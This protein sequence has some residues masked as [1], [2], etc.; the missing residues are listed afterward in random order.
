MD[1]RKDASLVRC[2]SHRHSGYSGACVEQIRHLLKPLAI[3]YVDPTN[4][5]PEPRNARRHSRRQISQICA[6]M[7][8]FG[9]IVPV[10]VDEKN[11]VLAGHGRLQAALRLGLPEVP[12]V[13][14]EHLTPE[15]KRAFRLA[16]NRLA[17]L[18]TWDEELLK[19]ELEELSVLDLHFE[20]EVTGFDSADLDRLVEPP[21]KGIHDPD[22][23]LPDISECAV[24]KR[25]DVWKAGNHLIICGD[26]RERST[27]AA[28]LGAT[29]VDMVFT[30]PPY[31]VPVFGHVT[32]RSTHREF[33]MANGEMTPRDFS[34]FLESVF[35][36][37]KQVSH[38]GAIHFICI[39]WRH[40]AELLAGADS[41]Y[42]A[43]KQLCIW[44]KDNAGMGSFYRSGHEL[45]FVFKVGDAPH[46]NNFGLGERGRY[47]TN[48][49]QYPSPQSRASSSDL[50]SLHPTVKPVSL[51]ADAIKDC[52]RRGAIIL[53]PFGG[54]G[55]TVIAAERTRRCAR[56]AELDPL[57][58]D[59]I[60]RRW[61]QATGA[62]AMLADTKQSFD[63]LAAQRRNREACN[64]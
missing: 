19:I 37:M 45:V 3:S 22:D 63:E 59:L 15:Q 18:S 17:E 58:V 41:V 49:W 53:D 64:E 40:I 38:D 16:D 57:Y 1:E 44:I 28:L 21:S 48:V 13:Q 6:S 4:L 51:V 7:R 33:L 36:L 8:E 25:G 56:V 35:G 32:S 62:A 43:P 54:S 30:D 20:F 61:Q 5:S 10:L 47:R 34:L 14:L 11:T 42:G 9:F 50:L 23:Q 60:I 31:N 52:S 46:I 27:Y 29:T 12:I 39:D 24:S 26:A 55:T 2:R